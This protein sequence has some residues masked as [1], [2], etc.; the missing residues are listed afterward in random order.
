MK[1]QYSV[2]TCRRLASISREQNLVIPRRPSRYE[3]GAILN[4]AVTGLVPAVTGRAELE[5]EAFLGGGFAGQVYRCRL[6]A[7][8]TE[9]EASLDGLQVG[10]LYAVK[11]IIPPSSFARRFRNAVYWLAFQGPF[12]AQVNYGACR[13]GLIWQKL[14]RRGARVAFGRNTAV[15]DAYAT[16]WDPTLNAFGEITE[17]VEG[18]MW[19]L[20]SDPHPLKRRHWPSVP[21][22]ETRSAE[23]IAKRR[24]MSDLVALLHE[25]GAAELARQYEWSTMKSQPNVMKRT[26]VGEEGP[27]G[28][29][30]AIDFRAGLALLPFLPMSPGDIPLIVKGIVRRHTLVQFDRCDLNRLNRFVER[31]ADAFADLAPLLEEL[32]ERD[33]EYRRSL[34]DLTHHGWRL[35]D[36]ELRADVRG[37]LVEGYEADDVVDPEFARRLRAGGMV[38]AAF[39][40]LGLFPWVGKRLRRFWGNRRHRRHVVRMIISPA[41]LLRAIRSRAAWELIDWHRSGRVNE[42]RALYLARHPLRF[43]MER[44]TLGILPF[45][46][47]H[48]SL[49]EPAF[50][51]RTFGR[52]AGFVWLF[53]RRAEFREEWFLSLLREGEDDGMLSAAERE[54]ITEHVRDPFIVKYLKCLAVHFATLPVTQIVSVVAGAAV[55]AWLLGQGKSWEVA[56]GAF[57]AVVA[58][59]QILPVSP[60]SIC[61]GSYVLYLMIRERDVRSYLIAAPLS[62]VKYIGYLA[63]PLQMVTRYPA[64]AQFL[65]GRWATG[66][67]HVIPVFGEK[68]ALLEHWVFDLFFNIPQAVGIWCRPRL[69]GLLT[70]WMISGLALCAGLLTWLQPPLTGKLTIN[71]LLATLCVFVLPRVLFLPLLADTDKASRG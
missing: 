41:Y 12:S 50:L 29:L 37:G 42:T 58:L 19:L 38:F 47:L 31:H 27:S 8:D 49:T 36:P 67:V 48:R 9:T 53:W 64:L 25:M 30:C 39:Y 32:P 51:V 46:F 10:E 40:V 43:L 52:L 14:V 3:K 28:G 34:P 4:V 62:F 2:E 13:S 56:A 35:G 1:F 71:L 7:L 20:E 45:P 55:V 26:D 68:G 5:I 60:G 6:L 63:F 61:R 66:A 18:R 65:A 15:K 16:F 57:V 21:L 33:R 70:A 11:L 54:R 44:E 24:F 17:W 23:Y 22:T 59:F 69:K